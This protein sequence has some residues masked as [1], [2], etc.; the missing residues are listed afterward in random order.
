MTTTGSR[1]RVRSDEDGRL[2]AECSAC[3]TELVLAPGADVV[4]ALTALDKA[5]PARAHARRTSAAPAGWVLR[6]PGTGPRRR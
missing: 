4:A 2:T 5:H 6:T 3:T 1:T